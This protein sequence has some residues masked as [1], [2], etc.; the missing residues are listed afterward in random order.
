MIE[1]FIHSYVSKLTKE[2]I[3]RFASDNQI[4]LSSQEV[5][6]IYREI[7]ENWQSFLYN[8]EVAFARVKTE[9]SP[10]TYEHIIYFYRLYSTKLSPFV[11]FH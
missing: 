9:V 8:P 4:T 6:I 2:D 3:I 5:D 1:K 11:N 7:K 10:S